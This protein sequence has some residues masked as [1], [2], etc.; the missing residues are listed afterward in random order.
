DLV[1]DVGVG[2]RRIGYTGQSSSDAL[3]KEIADRCLWND[4]YAVRSERNSINRI[5]QAGD[6]GQV[7]FHLPDVLEILLGR[8]GNERTADRCSERDR[9]AVD[10]VVVSGTASV[11]H[12]EDRAE[13]GNH[14]AVRR[15]SRSRNGLLDVCSD[16]VRNVVSETEEHG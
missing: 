3:C 6:N 2:Y 11:Q 10:P 4:L 15:Q 8:A 5:T 12:A 1:S 7:R 9:I 14:V 13:R 16:R